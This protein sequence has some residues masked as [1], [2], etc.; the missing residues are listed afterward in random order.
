VVTS[1]A[2]DPTRQV[3]GPIAPR[4]APEKRKVTDLFGDREGPVKVTVSPETENPT[5]PADV[6]RMPGATS[7]TVQ[8]AAVVPSFATTTTP[9]TDPRRPAEA[10]SRA[11]KS[12]EAA[13]FFDGVAEGLR[14]GD[15][16]FRATGERDNEGDAEGDAEGV[17]DGDDE[18]MANTGIIIKGGPGS[19]APVSR[20]TTPDTPMQTTTNATTSEYR[21]RDTNAMASDLRVCRVDQPGLRRGPERA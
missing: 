15:G 9:R 20:A 8:G 16:D 18:G 11:A 17:R 1:Q 6:T 13:G 12:G 3:I 7:T 5:P 14:D 10:K 19:G 21:C 4:A 2:W